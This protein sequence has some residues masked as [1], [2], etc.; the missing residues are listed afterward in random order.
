MENDG[1]PWLESPLTSTNLKS[2]L[3][4]KL[5]RLG[6]RGFF[7]PNRGYSFVKNGIQGNVFILS[8]NEF[9]EFSIV[10]PFHGFIG[11]FCGFTR[12]IK[13]DLKIQMLIRKVFLAIAGFFLPY[14]V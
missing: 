9:Y 14:P 12:S 4:S 2:P 11:K 7:R 8:A 1:E 10:G 6:G 5:N 3:D 13:T